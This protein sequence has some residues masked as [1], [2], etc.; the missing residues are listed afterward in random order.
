[1]FQ[2]ACWWTNG[3]VW[4]KAEVRYRMFLEKRKQGLKLISRG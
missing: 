4:E 3:I 2:E 1:M